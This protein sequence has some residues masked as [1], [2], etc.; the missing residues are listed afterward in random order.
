MSKRPL[1]WIEHELEQLDATQLRRNLAVRRGS[2]SASRIELNSQ[3]CVNFGSNDYLGLASEQR[4]V[5]AA[6]GAARRVGW[7]SGASPLVSGRESLHQAL[8]AALA[9]FEQVD[10]ALLFPTGFAANV[11]AIT[12]LVGR[13][14]IVF[15]DAENHASIIDGCRLSRA[16]VQ[17]YPHRNVDVLRSQLMQ[18]GGFGKRLIVTDALFSMSGDEAPLT[19]LCELAE[20]FDAMLYVDEAHATGVY[21]DGGRG[22]SDWHNVEDGIHVRV[23]TLS[24]ALGGHGGFVVGSRYLI[25]L[26]AN[27]A[28]PY[29][30]S[31]A[32]PAA[33]CAAALES[34]SI[35]QSEPARRIALRQRSDQL[36][37]TLAELGWDTGSSTS[38]IMPIRIGCPGQTLELARCL[39]ESGY[40]VPAIRPP[41][42]AEGCSLL[43]IGLCYPHGSEDIQGLV[44]AL[45]KFT[46]LPATQ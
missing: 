46:P 7:G 26:L 30:Y 4:V 44:A 34:L 9:K 38:Q 8:E 15:S 17:V 42:V 16:R 23:G 12:T 10:A 6:C 31:T 11:G 41:S 35:V 45:N 1:A 24:K 22:V 32:S 14:D 28:R 43:R 2:Q 20:R 37:A 21:G 33:A 25:D 19:Q 29:V 3:Q 5:D 27:R 40:Y 39:R 36:R 13:G 18:A